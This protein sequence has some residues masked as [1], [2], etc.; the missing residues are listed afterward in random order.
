MPRCHT[1]YLTREKAK[2]MALNIKTQYALAIRDHVLALPPGHRNGITGFWVAALNR[3]QSETIIRIAFMN[4]HRF[5]MEADIDPRGTHVMVRERIEE[6]LDHERLKRRDHP[7]PDAEML[8]KV[9][10]CTN[11]RRIVVAFRNARAFDRDIHY[12]GRNP[13]WYTAD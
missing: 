1:S 9:Q 11:G 10:N 8:Q 13:I 5:V 7:L 2:F 3:V 12:V 4:D 6:Y